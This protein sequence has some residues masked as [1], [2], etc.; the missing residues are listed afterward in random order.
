MKKIGI[1]SGLL[2]FAC[3]VLWAKEYGYI[4][5]EGDKETPFYVK[6]EGKMTPRLGKNYCI[7]SNLD[8]G[9]NNIEILFQQN[10]YPP[11]KF[12]IKVPEGGSRGFKI[13][14]VN[15]QQ[16]SLLDLMQGHYLQTGNK[17]TDDIVS[18]AS[19]VVN[20]PNITTPEPSRTAKLDHFGTDIPSFEPKSNSK[21]KGAKKNNNKTP[22]VPETPI[23]IESKFIDNIELNNGQDSR[24]ASKANPKNN[25]DNKMTSQSTDIAS[26]EV[27]TKTE[28]A[29][30]STII[31]NG[32]CNPSISNDEFQN[33]AEKI[34]AFEDDNARLKA[35]NKNKGKLCFS[36][37]QIRI[38]ASSME[39]QS[40]RYEVTRVLYSQTSDID[41]YSKLESLFKT[42]FLKEKFRAIIE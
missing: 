22:K 16:M 13:I 18:E 42:N 2:L 26:T 12:L 14:K 30:T 5:I 25:R 9:I 15:D 4:Y 40:A 6:I 19:V 29:T 20:A 38:L 31:T 35:L 1:L 17:A 27:T 37:E 41:N 21:D 10:K 8:A 3:N 28:P 23:A 24:A 32:K 7:L 39:T 36:T 33:F 34:L 11:Q